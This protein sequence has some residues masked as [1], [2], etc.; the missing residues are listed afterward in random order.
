MNGNAKATCIYVSNTRNHV[1][2]TFDKNS[3]FAKK[4]GSITIFS[5]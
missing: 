2:D 4:L 3:F 1:M 5:A